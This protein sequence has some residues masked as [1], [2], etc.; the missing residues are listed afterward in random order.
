[1]LGSQSEEVGEHEHEDNCFATITRIR[2]V[3]LSWLGLEAVLTRW[4]WR[5]SSHH[6]IRRL[7]CGNVWLHLPLPRLFRQQLA[8]QL[9]PLLAKRRIASTAKENNDIQQETLRPD[10]RIWN[11][12]PTCPRKRASLVSS[13]SCSTYRYMAWVRHSLLC[14]QLVMQKVLPHKQATQRCQHRQSHAGNE[15]ASEHIL[16]ESKHQLSS[17]PSGKWSISSRLFLIFLIICALP[18][19]FPYFVLK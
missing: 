3:S 6:R 2:K 8:N 10:T 18:D 17:Q 5:H 9:D 1:M 14:V 7:G 15:G 11:S 13:L 16:V 12:I 19:I 4:A